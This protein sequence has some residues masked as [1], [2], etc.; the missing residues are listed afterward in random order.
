MTFFRLKQVCLLLTFL[1]SYFTGYAQGD[2]FAEII[3]ETPTTV[4]VR[5]ANI[6][7]KTFHFKPEISIGNTLFNVSNNANLKLEPTESVTLIHQTIT[8]LNIANPT[9]LLTVRQNCHSTTNPSCTTNT[10]ELSSVITPLPVT[11]TKFNGQHKGTHTLLRWDTATE[12]DTDAFHVQRSEDGHT[13]TT[14]GLVN[15]KGNTSLRQSY[16]F[17]DYQRTTHT[18]YYRLLIMDFDGSYEYT[19]TIALVGM[20]GTYTYLGFTLNH[21][22]TPERLVVRDSSGKTLLSVGVGLKT[23]TLPLLGSGV[24]IITLHTDTKRHV[25]K[26]IHR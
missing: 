10:R 22:E 18:V 12:I 1:F 15:A 17:E 3:N 14:I 6:G 8:A 25:R 23:Q 13:Y 11:I 20:Q 9:Y 19:K 16:A 21:N 2:L 5:Y 24:Y 4:T 26:I 7:V